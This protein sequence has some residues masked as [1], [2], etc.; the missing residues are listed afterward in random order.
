M[1]LKRVLNTYKFDHVEWIKLTQDTVQVKKGKKN[2]EFQKSW[3]I[4]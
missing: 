1:R 3:Y 2:F 4:F